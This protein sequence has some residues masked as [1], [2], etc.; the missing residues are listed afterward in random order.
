MLIILHIFV[1]IILFKI[2]N[3]ITTFTIP[4]HLVPFNKRN[5]YKNVIELSSNDFRL[6]VNLSDGKDDY[7]Y[8]ELFQIR[9]IE[10]FDEN[11]IKTK[12]GFRTGHI[13][14]ELVVEYNWSLLGEVYD[15]TIS[16]LQKV[17]AYSLSDEFYKYFINN[18]KAFKRFLDEGTGKNNE[19]LSEILDELKK[20]LNKSNKFIKEYYEERNRLEKKF[21]V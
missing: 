4:A 14:Y 9:N 10:S 20:D 17:Y 8:C 7:L 21:T 5:E 6:L 19:I 2:K 16:P 12:S 15:D 18:C 3:M 13:N 1:K 11:P